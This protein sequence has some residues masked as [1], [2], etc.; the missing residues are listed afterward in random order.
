M[1]DEG[2]LAVRFQDLTTGEVALL[3]QDTLR[4]NPRD[5]EL[6]KALRQELTDRGRP[7]SEFDGEE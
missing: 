2:G 7:D 6:I 1:A 4:E 5:E 3:L